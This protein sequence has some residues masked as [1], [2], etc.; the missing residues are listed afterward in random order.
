MQLRWMKEF[1]S[2][3]VKIRD[4]GGDFCW[5]IINIYGPVKI[6]LKGLFLQ[7]LY[8]KIKNTYVPVMVGVILI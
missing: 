5:E 2:Q 3:S 8:R 6:E 4:R 7:K 1:F